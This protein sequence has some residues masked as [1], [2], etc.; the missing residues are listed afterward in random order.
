MTWTLPVLVDGPHAG[1]LVHVPEGE[2]AYV[3]RDEA[4][5]ATTMYHRASLGFGAVRVVHYWTV[6]PLDTA[7]AVAAWDVMIDAARLGLFVRAEAEREQAGPRRDVVGE[8]PTP[9]T[10]VLRTAREAGAVSS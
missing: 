5:G 8:R 2:H 7:R 10:D 4:T 1:E 9:A 3:V 6:E